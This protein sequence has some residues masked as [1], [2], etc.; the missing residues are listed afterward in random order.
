MTL[1]TYGD[2]ILSYSYD[3]GAYGKTRLTRASDGAHSM[4]WQYDSRGRVVSKT[5]TVSGVTSS[6]GY[7]YTNGRLTS[8]TT[9]SGQTITYTYA[10][11]QVSG[12]AVNG[13]PLISGVLYQ[14]FGPTR[15]WTWGNNSAE[16]RLY[17]EDGNPSQ[18]SAIETTSYT[19]DNAF[20]VVGADHAANSNLSWSYD[21]DSLDRLTTATNTN[22]HLT[23]TYDAVGNRLSQGGAPGPTYSAANLTMTYNDRGRLSSV[24]AGS[25]ATSYIYNAMGQR[26]Q[27]NGASRTLFSY[28]EAGHLLGE[29]SSTGAL[30]Q[31]TV[32]LEDIPIA[33]LRPKAGGGIDVYY[34]HT[35]YLN[36][37]RLITRAT[38]NAIVWRWDRD[39]F[40]SVAPDSNP[41][42]LRTFVYNL[43]LPGQYCDAE[44]GFTYNMARYYDGQTGRYVQSDAVGLGGGINT[45]SYVE[46]DP[47]RRV[48]SLGLTSSFGFFVH[49]SVA[50]VAA[51]GPY[52][53][54]QGYRDSEA[55][56]QATYYSDLP[57]SWN[58]QADA[59]RHCTW[60]CLMSRS[61]GAEKA[62]IVGFVHESMDDKY[63]HQ[64]LDELQM[65]LMNNAAG[66]CVAK[67]GKKRCVDLCMD[68][69]KNG[70]LYALGGIHMA[71]P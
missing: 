45:Y 7:S 23:W 19:V 50:E 16:V 69:L 6:V 53:A 40:G 9:P 35:D 63:H 27:K 2:Q 56:Q 66:R 10:N 55:A 57:G 30:I 12:V 13:T 5:Q 62:A 48:D 21:Y 22:A 4:T 15:G 25:Q 60:S 17:D 29:Y 36:A 28:D 38:D 18:I 70:G 46:N 47:I 58:G 8:L 71:A 41:S 61:I 67:N 3:A 24:T 42:N 68:K 44:T 26:I 64:P 51:V 34:V 49:T 31:E 1:A 52:A 20:R 39:P 14:P 43:R 33:T 59:F 37:P 32:W 54:F 65:D 11:G